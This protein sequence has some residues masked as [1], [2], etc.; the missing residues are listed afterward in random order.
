MDQSWEFSCPQGLWDGSTQGQT[1]EGSPEQRCFSLCSICT[2][3]WFLLLLCLVPWLLLV[4]SV[5]LAA[6]SPAVMGQ[7]GLF[8]GA[9]PDPRSHSQ[10]L[11]SASQSCQPKEENPSVVFP[12]WQSRPVGTCLLTVCA[13]VITFGGV[14]WGPCCLILVF[15]GTYMSCKQ[16]VVCVGPSSVCQF[17]ACSWAVWKLMLSSV[18]STFFL[19]TICLIFLLF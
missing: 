11:P 8:S 3:L 14:T 7:V 5:G 9:V 15:S 4:N 1:A 12:S 2:Y 17:S 10:I 19:S 18:G 6:P 16:E 13:H